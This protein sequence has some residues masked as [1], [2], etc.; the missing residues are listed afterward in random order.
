MQASR[1]RRRRRRRTGHGPVGRFARFHSLQPHARPFVYMFHYSRRRTVVA[2]TTFRMTPET[3]PFELLPVALSPP[4]LPQCPTSRRTWSRRGWKSS[5]SGTPDRSGK[6]SSQV[7]HKCIRSCN[8]APFG[9]LCFRGKNINC[10]LNRNFL[11]ISKLLRW[12]WLNVCC[13]FRVT[14]LPRA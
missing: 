2:V 12:N 10:A 4:G 7:S 8:C 11:K 14:E 3:F 1:R 13:E 9:F 6:V 5:S